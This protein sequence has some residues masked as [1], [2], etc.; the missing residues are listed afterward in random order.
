M[1]TIV[2]CV[3]M[4]VVSCGLAMADEQ[5]NPRKLIGKW[6]L[7]DAKK[8]QS[9]TLEF[10]ENKKISVTAGEPGKENKIEGTYEV[11]ENNKLSVALKLNDEDI[12]ESLTI[13]SL[14]D[15]ELLT[16]DS[17]GKIGVMRKKKK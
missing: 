13:K 1:R 5:I 7:I 10:M 12:K 2:G 3:A 15:D 16:E 11:H 8:G 6:E 4:F 9:L 14:T 17:K